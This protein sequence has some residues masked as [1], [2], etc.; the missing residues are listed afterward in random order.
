MGAVSNILLKSIV[1][2]SVMKAGFA[3]LRP[4]RIVCVMCV[5][6]MFVEGLGLTPGWAGRVGCVVLFCRTNFTSI[7]RGWIEV[8]LVTRRLISK[9]LVGLQNEDKDD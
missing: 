5:K 7:F 6:G 8:I 2:R 1:V 3:A 4:S 9:W